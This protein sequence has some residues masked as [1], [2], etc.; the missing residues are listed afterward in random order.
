LKDRFFKNDN[1]V[2]LS[3]TIS[4]IFVI[5]LGVAFFGTS[6]EDY[7]EDYKITQK[8]CHNEMLINNT[9]E[10]QKDSLYDQLFN[11]QEKFSDLGCDI[12]KRHN[13]LNSSLTCELLEKELKN[14]SNRIDVIWKDL[15]YYE[16]VCEQ[17]EVDEIRY[18][19]SCNGNACG[20]ALIYKEDLTKEW[21][22][23]NSD[24]CFDLKDLSWYNQ[25]SPYW[26]DLICSKYK[27][28]NYT[29]EV[30]N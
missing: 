7:K 2:A 14:Y 21:L 19:E 28:G 22:N 9:L 3:L 20:G 18:K 26:N 12:L 30:L 16:E 27:L 1:F 25:T 11:I 13:V 24:E 8:S 10:H 23:T 6:R 17:V 4:I 29:I 5:I 15:F